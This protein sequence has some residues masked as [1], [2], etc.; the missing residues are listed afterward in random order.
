M[1]K[2]I[3]HKVKRQII[4]SQQITITFMTLLVALIYKELIKITKKKIVPIK[5]LARNINW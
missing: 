3:L 4:N 2:N 1:P 5:K